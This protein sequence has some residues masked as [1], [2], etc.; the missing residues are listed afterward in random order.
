MRKMMMVSL[1]GLDDQELFVRMRHDG[2]IIRREVFKTFVVEIP[3][4]DPNYEKIINI[5]KEYKN[6]SEPMR[7]VDFFDNIPM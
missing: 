5:A 2:T 6:I 1:V 4:D 3:E 7:Y